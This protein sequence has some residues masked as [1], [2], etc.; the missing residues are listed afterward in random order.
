[1][2]M[3]AVIP[4]MRLQARHKLIV[5]AIAAAGVVLAGGLLS[6]AD[7]GRAPA[8]MSSATVNAQATTAFQKGPVTGLPLP[9]FVSLK[10]S[11]V[12]VRRGP[13]TRYRVD[14]EFTMRGLPVEI[15]AE[16]GNW[17]KIRD[18]QGAEGWVHKALLSGRRTALVAPWDKDATV[19]LRAEPNGAVIARLR[20]G[21]VSTLESCG[22][23][24]CAVRAGGYK[25]YIAQDT[26]WGVYPGE[27]YER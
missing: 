3:G 27:R 12:R 20:G 7:A 22:G 25:G 16:Y 19:A 17:R 18:A 10:S 5:G 8:D 9:R 24:W 14:W 13:S 4:D 2:N 6:R 15:I 23:R 11:H 21:V 26:L 1:M